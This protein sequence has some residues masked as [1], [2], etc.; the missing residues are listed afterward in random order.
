MLVLR[1][2]GSGRYSDVFRVAWRRLAVILKV[3]YY[4]DTTL[5]G[6]SRAIRA[7]DYAEAKRVKRTDAVVVASQM[8]RIANSCIQKRVSPH[9]VLFYGDVDCKNFVHKIRHAI[10]ARKMSP[11]QLKYNNL[12][13]LEVFDSD[14]TSYLAHTR[15]TDAHMTS[16]LFQIVYTLAALQ[17][18]Y[19]GF[20][21]NDLSTNNILVK[22][23]PFAA[24]YRSG[25]GVFY[26]QSPVFV[27]ISDYDFTHIPGRVEN[28]RI[29]SGQY[30]ID[31]SDNPCYDTHFFLKTVGKCLAKSK[32][33][34]PGTM[35]F[36]RS[37]GLKSSDRPSVCVEALIPARL[38]QHTFFHTLACP[39]PKPGVPT[40]SYD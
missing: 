17:K 27:A 12:S 39:T 21:H 32:C 19:P 34:V 25:H 16:I 5:R 36:L 18:L 1:Y 28:E 26:A 6:F 13:F 35:K 30:S 40:F 38:L 31:A 11:I 23:K 22:K 33:R 14:L 15:V 10:P 24:W 20:R 37:V 7:L 4:R 9:F 2:I 3:S 8:G 29:V